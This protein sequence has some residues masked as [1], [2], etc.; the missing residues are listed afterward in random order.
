MNKII[1]NQG[2]FKLEELELQHGTLTIGRS[3]SNDIQLDDP[4][5]SSHHA[6]VV[7]LFDVSFI[8]DLDSTNGTLVNGK[9]IAKHTLHSGDVISLGKHQLLFQ[10][11]KK[12]QDESGSD[13]TMIMNNQDMKSVLS[14][15]MDTRVEDG[16]KL[17]DKSQSQPPQSANQEPQPVDPKSFAYIPPS[18]KPKET[19]LP[20]NR[21]IGSIVKSAVQSDVRNLSAASD[22]SKQSASP[23]PA[24]SFIPQETQKL[25]DTEETQ[26]Y[27]EGD[28]V[29]NPTTIPPN[30]PT[31]ET[32]MYKKGDI[33]EN[34]KSIPFN[35][36]AVRPKPKIKSIVDPSAEPAANHIRSNHADERQAV[37]DETML[38]LIIQKDRDFP[39]GS[40]LFGSIQTVLAFLF[41]A[42]VGAI[43]YIT[44]LWSPVL[45]PQR[46][47]NPVNYLAKTQST[48][49]ED[50]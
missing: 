48:Q 16:V 42:I 9:A 43:M 17:S 3:K 28:I 24:D 38:K 45:W 25:F 36:P 29:E 23:P 20:R 18:E 46:K 10:G 13:E 34:P 50:Q 37:S 32:Q 44:F 40:G 8:Q 27:K 1:V 11:D 49:R 21:D 2:T 19:P 35:K 22:S 47:A 26:M 39:K 4:A 30:K 12:I 7:T 15:Y 14:E 33:I 41:L 31:E 6:K 5:V